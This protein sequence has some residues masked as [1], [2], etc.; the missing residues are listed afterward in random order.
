VGLNRALVDRARRVYSAEDPAGTWQEGAPPGDQRAG[1]WFKVRLR[2]QSASN[3][4]GDNSAQY[5]DER[6]RLLIGLRYLDGAPLV[7]AGEFVGFD[8][9]DWLEIESAELGAGR[10]KA[11]AAAKPMR[12]RKSLVGFRVELVRP[13]EA[14]VEEEPGVDD[15]IAARRAEPVD[16][17]TEMG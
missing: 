14:E 9:D 5:V 12:R 17:L 16:L 13:R 2:P 11:Q 4:G 1:P 10:W 7:V 15:P 8:A 6:A 3:T